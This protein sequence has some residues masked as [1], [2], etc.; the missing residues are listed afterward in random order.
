MLLL[1]FGDPSPLL[2]AGLYMAGILGGYV[3]LCTPDEWQRAWE[4]VREVFSPSRRSD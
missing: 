3:L 1:T 4:V 2:L